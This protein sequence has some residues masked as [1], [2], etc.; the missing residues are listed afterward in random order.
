MSNIR[1]ERRAARSSASGTTL[2][3]HSSDTAYTRTAIGLHWIIFV[4]I[5]AGWALGQYMTGLPFSPQKL[6]YVAWHKW[7][8][9]TAF[10]LTALRLAWRAF[11]APPA[12]PASMTAFEQ[13][14]ATSMHVLLY[15]LVVV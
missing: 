4:T 5:A 14:A 10:L 1:A 9:V 12:L 6:R 3:M 15:V 11:H 7:I 13:R 8:G 2:S